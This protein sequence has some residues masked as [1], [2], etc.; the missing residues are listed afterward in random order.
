MHQPIPMH[1]QEREYAEAA[2][3]PCKRCD[4][5]TV[6]WQQSPKT[7][8]WYLTEIFEDLDGRTFTHRTLFHS[9]Y[10][11]NDEHALVQAQ[12]KAQ[13]QEER[14]RNDKHTAKVIAD[15]KRAELEHF[16]ALDSLV[17]DDPDAALVKLHE[18]QAERE[19]ELRD[20]VSMDYFTEH[21]HWVQKLDKLHADISALEAALDDAGRLF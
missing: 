15:R 11:G 19:R 21:C 8:K 6:T 1:K 14:D 9:E 5:Q 10:C 7:N 16:L 18:L 20:P 12:I 3:K 13:E 4:S 17:D 2:R